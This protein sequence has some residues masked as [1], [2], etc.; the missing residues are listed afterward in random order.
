MKKVSLLVA[1]LI[2]GVSALLFDLAVAREEIPVVQ[3]DVPSLEGGTISDNLLDVTTVPFL[4]L[5]PAIGGE[6]E[7]AQAGG[8]SPHKGGAENG[9]DLSKDGFGLNSTTGPQCATPTGPLPPPGWTLT[10][11]ATVPTCSYPYTSGYYSVCFGPNHYCFNQVSYT[12]YNDIPVGGTLRFCSVIGVPNGWSVT[13]AGLPS[14]CPNSGDD[15]VMQH[16]SCVAGDTNCYPQS[17][18]ISASPQTLTV[19][20]G[21]SAGS[22]TVNWNTVNYS[23]PCVWIQNS[24]GSP[25]S[26]WRCSGSGAH[27][28][29][30]PYV[31]PGGTTTF[32]ISN[33]GNSSP[34]PNIAQVVVRAGRGTAPS[35]SASPQTVQIPTGSS[36]GSTTISYNLTGSGHASM[37][38]W[39]Q[40][41]GGS[42]SVWACAVGA[43]WSGIWPYVPRGGTT[44]FWL[45]PS[46]TSST[47]ELVSVTV[48]GVAQN[49]AP[50]ITAS[51]QVVTIP[52]GQQSGSST[53]SYDLTGT[54]YTQ[55]CMW[56]QNSDAA[57]PGLWRCNVGLTYTDVWP[58]VPRDGTST[59][60]LSPN[61]TSFTPRLAQVVVTGQ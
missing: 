13:Q 59:I 45:S 61:S 3:T 34:S 55:M 11:A 35:I 38:V 42:S 19:P 24:G 33:G 50:R 39:Q 57:S 41:T 54:G 37:C 31:P 12:S 16:T 29:V 10:A 14:S 1:T 43:T 48:T 21:Q 28:D 47:P 32:W 7:G 36:S 26:L 58:W 15:W 8:G 5:P 20:Y 6:Y 22:T 23:N 40:S 49:T 18:S 52:V 2:V 46:S 60:W 51:P 30:W 17:A 9:F 4:A 53:I 27:S 44:R 56:Q 25:S